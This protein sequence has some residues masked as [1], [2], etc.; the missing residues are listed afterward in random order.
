[1]RSPAVLLYLALALAA[2]LVVGCFFLAPRVTGTPAPH[3][4]AA[5][6]VT[7]SE[8]S[9]PTTSTPVYHYEGIASWMPAKYGRDYLAM[10]LP[11]GTVVTICGPGG[12]WRNAVVMDYGPSGR[13][14]PDRIAD[15]AVGRWESICG[16]PKEL[17]LCPVSVDVV[18]RVPLP[19]TSTEE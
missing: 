18:R 19:E 7:A 1:V 14:H 13:I 2:W 11:K 12:C 5:V 10:R 4:P 17:G 3:G 16:V 8:G 6:N 9:E 15:I